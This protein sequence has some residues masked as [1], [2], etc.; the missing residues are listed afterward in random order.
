MAALAY[1]GIPMPETYEIIKS[2]AKKR[3]DKVFKYKEQFLNG[4][5]K[6]IEKSEN[7]TRDESLELA[8]KVWQ[9]LED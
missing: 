9:I 6:K 4:F 3:Y 7:K 5:S 1:A 8:N 2:I